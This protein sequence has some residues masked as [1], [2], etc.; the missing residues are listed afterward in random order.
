MA[1]I[2]GPTP[3]PNISISKPNIS[4]NSST[5]TVGNTDNATQ[6]PT[7]FYHLLDDTK[8]TDV[9]TGDSSLKSHLK[10]NINYNLNGLFLSNSNK[11]QLI[12]NKFTKLFNIE[13]AKDKIINTLKGINYANIS[14]ESQESVDNQVNN[15]INSETNRMQQDYKSQ[16]NQ[17]LATARAEAEKELGLDNGTNT[18][19][20][21]VGNNN[22]NLQLSPGLTDSINGKNNSSETEDGDLKKELFNAAKE[23]V[24]NGVNVKDIKFTM[25]MKGEV[26]ATKG[27][28]SITINPKDLK[29]S[30]SIR[31]G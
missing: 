7:I 10:Q 21:L 24:K 28:T 14:Q 15:E 9:N 4:S 23:F 2:A 8:D 3:E 17:A 26:T 30:A 29:V 11:S 13:N 16:V 5:S 31:F 19:G 18:Q 25:G 22:S 12:F 6:K 20:P 27:N 1:G